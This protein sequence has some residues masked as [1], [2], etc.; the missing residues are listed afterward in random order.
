MV[1][2]GKKRLLE[3]KVREFQREHAAS[4]WMHTVDRTSTSA[5]VTNQS[6]RN[7]ENSDSDG[8]KKPAKRRRIYTSK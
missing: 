5:Y 4:F 1:S 6:K 8:Q 7:K 3:R 2:Q